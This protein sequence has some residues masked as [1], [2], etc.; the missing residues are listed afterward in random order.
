MAFEELKNQAGQAQEETRAYIDSTFDYYKLWSFKVIMKSTTMGI[1]AILI[2]LCVI[3]ILLF[4][5]LAAAF[6]IG[7][8]LGSDALGFLII[9]GFY[10]I[11]LFL[12]LL[13]KDKIVEGPILRKFSEIYFND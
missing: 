2:T 11:C 10:L 4:G 5:S 8:A 6:G 9:G 12:V 7:N 1:K 13:I 3:M